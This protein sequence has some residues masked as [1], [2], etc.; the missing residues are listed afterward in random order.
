MYVCFVLFLGEATSSILFD[1]TGAN[2]MQKEN[3]TIN[4]FE[5]HS[6]SEDSDFMKA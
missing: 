2:P 1:V 4:D 5:Q 3:L 6:D